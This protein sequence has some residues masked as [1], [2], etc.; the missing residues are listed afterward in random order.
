MCRCAGTRCTG[1]SCHTPCYSAAMHDFLDRYGP[2][3]AAAAIAAIILSLGYIWLL[4][5]PTRI[6]LGLGIMF[7][8]GII[9]GWKARGDMGR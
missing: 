1:M 7:G 3:L 9:V 5:T 8:T 4:P 6:D 2:P